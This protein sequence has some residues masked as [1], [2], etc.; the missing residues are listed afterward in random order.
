MLR[1]NIQGAAKVRLQY[2]EKH[3]PETTKKEHI[4]ELRKS[5]ASSRVCVGRLWVYIYNH[6]NSSKSVKIV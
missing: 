3:M 6:S 2:Q 1:A 5:G 4:K